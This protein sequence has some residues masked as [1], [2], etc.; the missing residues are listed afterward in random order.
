MPNSRE[1]RAL[2]HGGLCWA[3]I[4]LPIKARPRRKA[5]TGGPEI[6]PRAKETGQPER[7]KVEANGPRAKTTAEFQEVPKKTENPRNPAES[8]NRPRNQEETPELSLE[9]PPKDAS[10][11]ES[12][13]SQGAPPED[14][15][16][17]MHD[18]GCQ[19]SNFAA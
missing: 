7:P 10:S 5:Q 18:R 3:P 2:W 16:C 14:E 12:A 19:L 4:Q 13:N 15:D 9:D 8:Q 11:Y 17:P 6:L 1:P